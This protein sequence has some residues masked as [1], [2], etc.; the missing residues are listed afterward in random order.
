[1]DTAGVADAATLSHSLIV[2]AIGV[3][4]SLLTTGAAVWWKH[5]REDRDRRRE[6]FANALVA[7]SQYLEFPY[8]IRRR[9]SSDPESERLRISSELK[10]VQ[11]QI[12]FYQAWLRTESK[13]GGR[14]YDRLVDE[15]RRVAGGQMNQAWREHA[16]TDDEGMNVPGIDRGEYLQLRDAYL[17]VVQRRLSWRGEFT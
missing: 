2:G 12:T 1:M 10:E 4:A 3:V 14:A 11:A 17:E 6:H 7:V 16:I 5:R 8:V 9:G 13:H 15:V